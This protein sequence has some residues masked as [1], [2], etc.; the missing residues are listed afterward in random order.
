MKSVAGKYKGKAIIVTVYI[1]D[2]VSS[3]VAEFFNLKPEDTPKIIGF[4][5]N[6]GKKYIFKDDLKEANLK[7]WCDKLIN[8]NLI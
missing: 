5:V 8:G 4:S 6:S 1:E 3:S 7:Q 2:E